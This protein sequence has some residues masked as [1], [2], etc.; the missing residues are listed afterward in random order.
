MS[1]NFATKRTAFLPGTKALLTLAALALL[2]ACQR[3]EEASA[4]EIRPVRVTTI[5]NRSASGTVSLT[6]TVQAQTEIN[7]AFRI[8]GRLIERTVDIGDSVKPGQLLR[9]PATGARWS[10]GRGR[11]PQAP[12]QNHQSGSAN[13]RAAAAKCRPGEL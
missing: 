10:A 11:L 3:A 7:Q 4:P 9:R 6:G 13:P 2:A 12:H 8:D 1:V 5:E